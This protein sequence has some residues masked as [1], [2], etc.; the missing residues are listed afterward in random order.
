ML[1][2]RRLM[3][4]ERQLEILRESNGQCKEDEKVVSEHFQKRWWGRQQPLEPDPRNIVASTVTAVEETATGSSLRRLSIAD[5]DPNG[6]RGCAYNS[7]SRS[8]KF[9]AYSTLKPPCSCRFM[10]CVWFHRPQRLA[11]AMVDP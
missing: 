4:A 11:K 9:D 3:Q 8:L 1:I 10:R 5:L 7:L 6:G 2:T